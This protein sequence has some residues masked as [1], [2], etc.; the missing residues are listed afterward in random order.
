MP[1]ATCKKVG[2]GHATGLRAVTCCQF[3]AS[4]ADGLSFKMMGTK[5]KQETVTWQAQSFDSIW[6]SARS[7]PTSPPHPLSTSLFRFLPPHP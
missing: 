2:C 3:T 4:T 7:R 6:I 5:N 1:N